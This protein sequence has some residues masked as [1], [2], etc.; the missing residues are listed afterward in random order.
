M[1]G[2]GRKPH[3]K[4]Q[5]SNP[6]RETKNQRRD[7]EIRDTA[8]REFSADSRER[9]DCYKSQS[10][11]PAWYAQNPQLLTD[12]ASFPYG[13]AVGSKLKLFSNDTFNGSIPG[14]LAY[15]FHPS[16]GVASDPTAPVNV[17]ARSIYSFVRHANS[18]HA[19]Y[20]SPDLMLYLLA[21]DS[22]YMM[23]SF[24]K[25]AIGVIH[26]YSVYNRYYP[27]AL[28]TAMGLDPAD[29][30][31]NSENFRG[32]INTYAVR[33][34][35][36]CVPNSMSYMARHTWMCEGIY[37]DSSAAKAQT[38]LYSPSS[39]FKFDLDDQGAGQLVPAAPW[40]YTA[41]DPD[42]PSVQLL[43]VSELEEFALGLLEP[44]LSNEDLNIMSGDILKAFGDSGVVR[45][46]GVPEGYMVL[47]QYNLEVLSQMENASVLA[48][49]VGG[50]TV[51]Q[52]VSVGGGFLKSQ[53]NTETFVGF[54][55]YNTN[56]TIQH[57]FTAADMA[58]MLDGRLLGNR[59]LNFHKQEVTPA[60]NMVAT[61]LMV[62]YVKPE[63]ANVQVQLDPQ[64]RATVGGILDSCGSEVISRATM[65]QYVW[66]SSGLELRPTP[67]GTLQASLYPS[68]A[69]PPYISAVSRGKVNF[70]ITTGISQ[71]D[72]HPGMWQFICREDANDMSKYIL[73][74][75]AKLPLQDIDNYTVISEDNI[76]N[77]HTTALLSMFSVP[78]M[79]RM[80]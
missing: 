47:P 78:Q 66:T 43:K 22:I 52:D 64:G 3:I 30:R 1:K 24:M 74:T 8:G 68:I 29:F 42:R 23:F 48:N 17:A 2:K 53:Q 63:G 28:L 73:S 44:I 40:L 79:G 45:V 19:N 72:W 14:V 18:G 71:F 36:M 49:T 31:A 16:I 7:V 54:N 25:R 70:E 62:N 50:T 58:E 51:T 56:S 61:R 77:L 46:T 76:R 38:Y 39:F 65:Y 26:D 20:D 10:N 13:V 21:M 35:S 11:D 69:N 4:G 41:T 5:K 9:R 80:M 57:F 12:Y 55:A 34:G 33:M 75:S 32:F 37:V 67:I 60:D 15:Y 59:I 6:K 27:D